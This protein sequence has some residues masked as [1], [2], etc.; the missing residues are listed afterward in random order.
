MK[1]QMLKIALILFMAMGAATADAETYDCKRCN[2]TGYELNMTRNCQ[3]CQG[4][5]KTTKMTR[6]STCNATGKV[7][8][9]FGDDVTCPSC[10]GERAKIEKSTC[11]RCNGSGSEKVTCMQCHGTGK[12]TR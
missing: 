11:T 8:D 10:H 3:A 7:K 9:R 1:K 5:G 12:V 2:G 4:T 6:C